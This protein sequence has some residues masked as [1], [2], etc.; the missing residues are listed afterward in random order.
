M[1]SNLHYILSPQI[2]TAVLCTLMVKKGQL[3]KLTKTFQLI[4][5]TPEYFNFKTILK[6]KLTLYWQVET[7]DQ[8]AHSLQSDLDLHWPQKAKELCLFIK[9]LTKACTMCFYSYN[10]TY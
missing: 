2:T 10:L 4:V 3:N 5:K 8:T 7:Q 1:Q 6:Q 9:D